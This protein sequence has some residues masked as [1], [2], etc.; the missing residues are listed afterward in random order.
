MKLRYILLILGVVITIAFAGLLHGS[1]I[2]FSCAECNTSDGCGGTIAAKDSTFP[3]EIHPYPDGCGDGIWPGGACTGECNVCSGS[4]AT[5][6]CQYTGGADDTCITNSGY[7]PIDCGE[8]TTYD[9]EGTWP[10]CTCDG[11]DG[12]ENPEDICGSV[13]FCE[14]SS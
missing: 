8:T 2:T 10:N 12:E 3:R 5:N 1:A 14:T 4:S 9:C 13:D 7:D 6:W 11:G